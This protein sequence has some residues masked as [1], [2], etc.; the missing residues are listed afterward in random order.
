MKQL[1]PDKIIALLFFALTILFLVVS[2]TNQAFFD[3]VFDRHHNQ[4]SWYIRPLFLIPFCFFAYKHSWTGI[5]ITIFCL[6]TSMFWFNR[7]D[8]IAD[9]VKTF[10]QF[11]KDWL[12][13]EWG[14]KKI[15]LIITVPISFI[16]LGLSFWKRSL[17]MG[18]GVMVLMATGKIVWSIQ[19]A[20]ES[21]ETIII[22][23]ILGLL[24][25]SGLIFYGFKRIEKSKTTNR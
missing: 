14:Y 20:G 11:E 23:A 21:G 16:A 18:L 13:G 12:Y 15:L 7:P 4:W 22:P 19:N 8:L 3:W 5:S 6:F 24:I 10:L 9:N 17:S 2:M 25:C 1:N